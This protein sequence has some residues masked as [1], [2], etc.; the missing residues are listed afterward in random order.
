MTIQSTSIVPDIENVLAM[1]DISKS[2]GLVAVLRHVSFAVRPGEVHALVG[3]NG[4]GKS[5]LM[6]IA[7]GVLRPDTGTVDICGAPL[8]SAS[9]HASKALGLSVVFQD[10]S[11]APDLTV[12]QNLQ[13]DLGGPGDPAMDIV[14]W[15]RRILGEFDARIDPTTFVRN[16]SV[17][18]K[19]IVEIARAVASQARVL[20]LDEPTAALAAN[21][22]KHLYDIIRKITQRGSAVIY[23]THRLPEI[24]ELAD[25]ASV[26]RN[27]EMV[28]HGKPVS[29]LTEALL[30]EHMIGRSVEMIFP[31]RP[32]LAG[33]LPV[34][35]RAT[36]LCGAMLNDVSLDLRRGEILGLFGIEGN[37]QR[38]FLRSLAG[39]EPWTGSIEIG[40]ERLQP[41]SPPK[42]VGAGISLVS[43]DRLGEALFPRMSIREN[44]TSGRLGPRSQGYLI[45]R[46]AE[47]AK[48]LDLAEMLNL[49]AASTE[50]PA[51]SLSGGNQQKVSIGAVMNGDASIYLIDEP[52]Q[53]VDINARAMLYTILRRL[54]DAG[55]AVV[56][57]SSD[58][59]EIA[60]LCDRAAVFSRGRIVETFPRDRLDEDRLVGIAVTAAVNTGEAAGRGRRSRYDDIRQSDATPVV[61][62]AIIATGL[63]LFGA[64]SLQ[65]FATAWTFSNILMAALPLCCV[66]L[67]QASVMLLGEIDLSVGPTAG[68]TTVA[69]VQFNAMGGNETAVL[70]IIAGAL[71]I[72]V[73]VGVANG[74][75]T[76]VLR[77]APL[78]ATLATFI[79]LQGVGL[80]WLPLQ[81]GVVPEPVSEAI[82]TNIWVFPWPFL[83]IVVIGAGLEF[84]YRRLPF[85]RRYRCVGSSPKAA[86]R[87]GIRERWM[88]FA[89]YAA[90]GFFAAC[91]GI[92]FAASIG[93]GSA[94][95]G[96]DFTLQSIAAVV[97]GG[98][99]T[100][101]G[102]GSVL[103][104]ILGAFVL[105][106]IATLTSFM[107]AGASAQYF[108][109]GGLTILAITLYSR[110][111]GDAFRDAAVR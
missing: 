85:G 81:G 82:R 27:G 39:L 45:R 104:P 72:G 41:A 55:A 1:A 61:I 10:S 76:Q 30:I 32:D 71:L 21:E 79:L 91:G 88:R 24:F 99:S 65:G 92:F 11:L 53:G 28:L 26:L 8:L 35:A 14:E 83:G 6:N 67:A 7:C 29:E 77:I 108:V 84:A 103:G 17:A 44:I 98:L 70:P 12:A 18:E 110:L 95:L 42:S 111:R 75:L 36:G 43:S 64:L 54:A 49:A 51:G 13:L 109:S 87:L 31:E 58:A 100:W 105:A 4:A 38:D 101:G 74:F 22:V 80:L 59:A 96:N 16:L 9:S 19:Q 47:V 69:L 50:Q 78:M 66:A 52:T 23:I 107:N 33:E 5:T 34:A 15:S 48:T 46:G 62:L 56:V 93:I 2:F 73:L 90:A 57:L 60:H 3:E 37:G 68:L 102:R 97:L 106:L 89:A 25:R 86:R 63:Y 94:T 20:V 40:G